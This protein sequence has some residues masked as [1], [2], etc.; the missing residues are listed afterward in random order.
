MKTGY[1]ESRVIAT[2]KDGF[3]QS[4]FNNEQQAIELAERLRKKGG[5][6]VKATSLFYNERTGYTFKKL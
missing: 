5:Y 3:M 2:D 4:V 6:K 1:I